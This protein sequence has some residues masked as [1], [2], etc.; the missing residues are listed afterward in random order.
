MSGFFGGATPGE[1]RERLARELEQ[2]QQRAAAAAGV[3]ADIEAVRERLSSPRRELTVVVDA[4]GRLLDVGLTEAA[5]QLGPAALGRLLVET[6]NK[7]QQAAGERAARIAAEA[8]GEDDPAVAHL[9]SE[10]EER[11]PKA[12]GIEYR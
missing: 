10:I 2:A 1:V 3:R 9:R 6:A 7:A 8:F 5:L 4:S 11:A 12:D